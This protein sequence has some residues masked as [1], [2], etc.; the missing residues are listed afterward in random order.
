L[1]KRCAASQQAHSINNVHFLHPVKRPKD[2][3]HR[4]QLFD[5][6]AETGDRRDLP[7]VT[8]SSRRHSSFNAIRLPRLEVDFEADLVVVVGKEDA[9]FPAKWPA[10]TSSDI[11]AAMTFP[12]VGK[13]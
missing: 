10:N 11:A 5:H 12:R 13:R 8:A 7:V 9:T 4:T 3:L 1:D 2:L 6:A